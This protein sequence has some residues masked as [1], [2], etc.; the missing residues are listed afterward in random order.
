MWIISL[1]EY[2][3]LGIY[4]AYTEYSGRR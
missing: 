1:A 3:K 4:L 2:I